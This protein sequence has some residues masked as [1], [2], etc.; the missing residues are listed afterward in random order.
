MTAPTARVKYGKTSYWSTKN[1][2]LAKGFLAFDTDT[3]SIRIG[4]GVHRWLDLPLF[5]PGG[6]GSALARDTSSVSVASLAAGSG[7]DASIVIGNQF[8]V[9]KI[10]FGG[11]ANVRF[12]LY[13]SS[14]HRSADT[15]RPVGTDPTGDHGCL[16]EF[17]STSGLTSAWLSPVPVGYLTSSGS[18][19]PARIDNMSLSPVTLTV[20]LTWMV[21]E[22]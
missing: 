3:G 18:S 11:T 5:S 16:L 19:V 9:L 20:T 4:D 10:D 6:S 12:R 14:A 1:P 13:A 15:S 17:V 22:P 21:L 7:A 8:S 2:V